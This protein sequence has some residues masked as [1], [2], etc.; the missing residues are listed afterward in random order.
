[1][2]YDTKELQVAEP[3]YRLRLISRAVDTPAPA[4]HKTNA[5]WCQDIKVKC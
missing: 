1:M 3:C 5:L 2:I 4:V